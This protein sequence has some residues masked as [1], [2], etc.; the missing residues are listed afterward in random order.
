MPVKIDKDKWSSSSRRSSEYTGQFKNEDF[1]TESIGYRCHKCFQACVFT[2]EEQKKAYEVNKKI[3]HYVP[4]LCPE[5]RAKYE[6]LKEQICNYQNNWNKNHESL[7]ADGFF[8]T[9]W[10]DKVREKNTY[11]KASDTTESMLS[12]LLRN[13]PVGK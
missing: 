10:L 8:L 7:K 3:I 6:E 1:Y 4:S 12:N 11:G 2:P 13:L 9:Q 5:C